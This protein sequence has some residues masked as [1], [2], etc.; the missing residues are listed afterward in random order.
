MAGGQPLTA[1][2]NIIGTGLT[3]RGEE[4]EERGAKLPFLSFFLVS[5][6]VDGMVF[7]IISALCDGTS[8]CIR[9]Q[10]HFQE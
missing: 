8:R 10:W 1:T 5:M 2:A 7:S 4:V 6:D 9:L 3:E